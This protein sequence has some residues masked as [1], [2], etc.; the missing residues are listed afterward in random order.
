[1]IEDRRLRAVPGKMQLK[2]PD[3]FE[4]CRVRRAA[5]KRGEVFDGAD[6]AFLGLRR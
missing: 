4:I 1:M 5:E 2:A 6:V 3:I